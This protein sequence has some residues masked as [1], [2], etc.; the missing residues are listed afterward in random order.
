MISRNDQSQDLSFTAFYV[1]SFICWS[2][3][4]ILKVISGKKLTLAAKMPE[5]HSLFLLSAVPQLQPAPPPSYL[6]RSSNYFLSWKRPRHWS[7]KP[8]ST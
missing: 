6:K 5:Q 7:E 8:A 2:F 3:L 1:V 4:L